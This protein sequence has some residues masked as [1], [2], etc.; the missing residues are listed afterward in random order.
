MS[1]MKSAIRV[2]VADDHP[3]VREGLRM[4]LEEMAEGFALVGMAADGAAAIRLI[5]QQQPDVVL[6]DVRMPVVD[7]VEAIKQIQKQWPHI[8]ILV[9]TTYNED[10]LM[11]RALQAGARGYLLKES[12]VDTLLQAIRAVAQG[13]MLVQPEVMKHLLARAASS[14]QQESLTEREL[15][16]LIGVADGKPSKEIARQLGITERT[17]RAHLTSIYT[18]LNVD[19]RTAAVKVALERGI[20]PSV[21]RS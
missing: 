14:V 15:E 2:V 20:L 16:V 13:E 4:M 12:D 8:A 5:E 9:L 1:E 11:I 18:K 21:K 10:E 19:S 17:I 7:G 6:M 3:V